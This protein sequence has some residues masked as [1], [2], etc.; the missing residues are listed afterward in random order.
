MKAFFSRRIGLE[1]G[2]EVPI[3]LGARLTGRVGAWNVGVLGVG[4]EAVGNGTDLTVAD[5]GHGV[6]RLKRDLGRRSSVGAIYT[7]RSPDGGADNELV[8][9]DLDFK[10]S[11]QSRFFLFGAETDTEGESGDSASLGAGYGYTA[12]TLRASFDFME[13]QAGFDPGLGFLQRRDF[14][15]YRPTARWE[16]RINKGVVR[17]WTLE[18][19]VDY[20]ERESTGQIES[21]KVLLAPIG[22]RTTGDD[23][24]RLAFVDDTEQLF[25]PFE[26]SPGVVIPPGLYRFD[27]VFLRGFSNR[28]RRVAWRGNINV[29][30]FYEG[31]R[32]GLS[33]VNYLRISRHLNT[34]L[35]WNFNDIELPQGDFDATIYGLRAN[36]SF[37]PDLRL[38]TF[39]QYNDAA[40]LVGLNLR[41]NWIYK[42]G[43]DLFVVYNENWDAPT[44]SARETARR[45][46]IVKFSYLWQP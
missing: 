24:F 44:F 33:L 43:A 31:D 13:A 39:L 28:G 9:I 7:R 18:A 22:M 8:G 26:I 37:T 3:D 34:E 27:S 36:L 2:E 10:P 38:N 46:L 42:P 35:S 23:R 20:Y 12:R 14:R 4:T 29:G 25:E 45:E 30:E 41:L 6:V 16:P 19:E 40:E 5:A 17:S 11:R 1:G 21:R 32:T 15:R